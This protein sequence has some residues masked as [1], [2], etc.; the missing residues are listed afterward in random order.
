MR[1][2]GNQKFF[3]IPAF[4]AQARPRSLKGVVQVCDHTNI[5]IN[6]ETK[7]LNTPANIGDDLKEGA[8]LEFSYYCTFDLCNI[9][10]EI[11]EEMHELLAHR[12]DEAKVGG[13]GGAA[14]TTV[15]VATIA[16]SM[17]MARLAL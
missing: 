8:E 3:Q 14:Q 4:G 1:K 12:E 7:R 13:T 2:Y 10:L 11:Q 5:N 6:G 9:K 17:A 16:F 15:A